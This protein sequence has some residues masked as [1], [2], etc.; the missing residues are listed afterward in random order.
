[1]TGGRTRYRGCVRNALDFALA[2]VA[3]N[4]RRSFTLNAAAAAAAT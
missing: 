2:A 1:M 4:F 3:Y